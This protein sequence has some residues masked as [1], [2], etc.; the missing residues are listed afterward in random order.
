MGI[1]IVASG[2]AWQGKE[3]PR[4]LN[5]LFLT[6]SAGL[7]TPVLAH[8]HLMGGTGMA[9]SADQMG[10][11][12]AHQAVKIGAITKSDWQETLDPDTSGVSVQLERGSAPRPSTARGIFLKVSPE[13]SICNC[14]PKRTRC[15]WLCCLTLALANSHSSHNKFHFSIVFLPARS[16]ALWVNLIKH[17]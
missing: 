11:G 3:T 8:P 14:S 17:T 10:N 9:L 4:S 6:S 2:R 16:L 5:H 15:H 1:C 13:R 7:Q 12:V